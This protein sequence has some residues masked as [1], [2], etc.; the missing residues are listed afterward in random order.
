MSVLDAVATV[1]A[2]AGA[3][4][5]CREI[6]RQV[7]DRRLWVPI[8]ATPETTVRGQLAV[9]ISTL[10]ERS[11]FERVAPGTF[12]L[13]N[14]APAAPMP[15]PGL[16]APTA[17]GAEAPTRLKFADAAEHVLRHFAGRQPMHYRE[18]TAKAIECGLLS[19]SGLTPA[20]TLYA[21]VLT[22]IARNVRRGQPPR[23]VRHGDGLVGLSE[24]LPS[25]LVHQIEAHNAAARRGLHQRLLAMPPAE[26]EALVGDLLAKLGFEEVSMAGLTPDGGLDARGTLVVADVI[27]IPMAVRV[28]RW[29]N[30]VQAN[31]VCSL[32]SGLGARERGLI[33]TTSDF[34]ASARAEAEIVD[35]APIALL[36]G[37]ELIGLLVA[38]GI[39]VQQQAYTLLTL[40]DQTTP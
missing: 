1:L 10:G 5:S 34:S 13:R 11:R 12:R 4:L 7:L 22:E 21:Q 20:T 23:F 35:A 25:G 17:G 27:R 31:V 15:L 3:P 29:R 16:A 24:W 37:K 38:Q 2:E 26:F 18:I 32:R 30:N 40:G 33:V 36:N 6:T 8:G 14:A 9:D 39:G 28:R 19:T